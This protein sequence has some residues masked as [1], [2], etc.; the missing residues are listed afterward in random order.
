MIDAR[1]IKFLLL[2]AGACGL[3]ASLMWIRGGATN[4]GPTLW[5][6]VLGAA[7]N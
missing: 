2:A 7:L 5:S 6:F 1:Y 3:F 4:I